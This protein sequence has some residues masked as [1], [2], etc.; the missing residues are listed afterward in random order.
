MW[1]RSL[2]GGERDHRCGLANRFRFALYSTTTGLFATH[3]RR[4]ARYLGLE[5]D[6]QRLLVETRSLQTTAEA[7][8]RRATRLAQLLDETTDQIGAFDADTLACVL[9]NRRTLTALGYSFDELSR[10]TLTDLAPSLDP[11]DLRTRLDHL[12]AGV[13]PSLTLETEYQRRDGSR[14]PVRLQVSYVALAPPPVFV[15][16]AADMT[17]QRALEEQLARAQRVEAIG[18]LAGGIAHDFNNLLTVISGSAELALEVLP[19]GAAGRDEIVQIREAG[20]RAARLT[21]QLLAFSRRQ[22]VK[23]VPWQLNT[24][25]QEMTSMLRRLIGEHIELRMD[26]AADLGIVRADRGQ[27]EQLLA[28]LFVNARD[29]MP[30]G[31]RLS[32]ETANVELDQAYAQAHLAVTPGPHVMI[33]VTDT[34]EGLSAEARSHLFEPFFTTKPKG[35]GTGLGLATVYGIVKQSGGNIWVYSEPGQGT[36]FKVYLPRVFEEMRE[37]VAA[38]PAT[39]VDHARQGET[40]LLV[41]DEREVRR[42]AARILS[43]RGYQVLAAEDGSE[44]LRVARDHAGEIQ[45]LLTDVVM[46]GLSG[47]ALAER[48][49][50]NRPRLKTLYMSGFT[51]NAIVHHGV[52]DRDV[53]FLQKPFT[54][55]SLAAAV[56]A[57]L[58]RP[59]PA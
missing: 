13:S 17:T 2:C 3:Q 36:T 22:I 15:V 20:E 32:I 31:G 10:R 57:A 8:D 34:G 26:L 53:A 7:A 48:L 35:R 5:L 16:I 58:I 40:V 33:A 19:D 41:E 56:R 46:P 27:L 9:A 49:K 4:R 55:Q 37:T 47:R 50:V 52:L 29:A 51:D 21:S 38:E 1:R 23:P 45:L 11:A 24:V 42:L 39:R 6:R 18:R 54:P 44:A 14:Y 59:K 12:R 43:E 25:V 28:N 30:D